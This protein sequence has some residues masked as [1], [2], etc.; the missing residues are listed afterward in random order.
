MSAKVYFFPH[1]FTDERR[2]ASIESGVTLASIV[3]T[4]RSDIPRGL[5]VRTF[6]NGMLISADKRQNTVLNDGDEII[7]RI[8]PA[9]PN[10]S[11]R[12][13]A[14]ES[15][16]IGGIAAMVLGV[17]LLVIGGILTGGA[18]WVAVGAAALVTSGVGLMI[19]GGLTASGVIG[20]PYA[21]EMGTKNH[22]SIR[23]ASNQSDPNG[24]VPLVLGRSLI[25]PGYLCP[26]Y[27]VISGVD[28]KDQY[29]YMSFIL[30]YAPLSVSNIKFGDFLVASNSANTTEGAIAVDGVLPGCE[31]ELRQ[32]GSVISFFEK[33]VI[34]QNFQ[35]LL[36]RYHVLSGLSL[37]VD[38]S[39][40]T[41][42]RS[43][44]DWTDSDNDVQVG[45]YVDFYGFSNYGNNKQFLV[46]GISSTVI[47][48]NQ[49]STLV[50]ETKSDV[51]VIVVP[52]TIQT[53]A[54]NTTQIAVTITFPKLVK[55]HTDDKLYTTV[56]VKPYY[57]LKAATGSPPNPWTL[58]G[59]FDAGSNSITRNKAETLRFTATSGTLTAGQYEV[60]VMRETEDSDD[61]KIVD[62]VYWTS[63]RS[64]T[65]IDAMPQ[66][67]REKV[68][69]LG[70]K[71]KASEAV[72][73]CITKLNCIVSA[74]YSY[75]ATEDTSHDWASII[76]SNPRNA[77]LAFVHAIMGPGNPRPR[78]TSQMDWAS[79]YAFAQWCD[80]AK[81][82]GDNAYKVEINGLITSSMKLSELIVKILSQARASLTMSE[83]K[84]GVV[85][86]AAQSTPKQHIGP[87]NSWGF[88]GK[89]V[90]GEEI[91]GYRVKFINADEEYTTDERIVLDDGYKYDTEADGI[92]RDCWGVD[93]TADA[94]Y[95]EAT[96]FETIEAGLNTNPAQVFG[97]CRYLLA[98]RKLRPELFTVNMDAENLA[99]KRGELVKVTHPAPRWGLA[100]G[101]LTGVTVDGGGNITAVETNN[102]LTME[103]G[104]DYAIRIR[105]ATGT[106]VY[107]TVV[108]DVGD[109]NELTLTTPISAGA[110]M[111]AE[112]DWFAFGIDELETVDCIVAGVD[113]NDDLSA[114]LTLFEAAPAVHTADTGAIPDFVS[115]V[116]FGPVPSAPSTKS[117]VFPP[118]PDVIPYPSE[119]ALSTLSDTVD[120]DGQYGIYNGQR[121]FGTT[122]STW[123]LDDAGQTA[124]DVAALIPIY[125]PAYLGAHLDGAPATA[126]NG[127]SY[128]RYSVTSG[129]EN[130]GV[131]TYDGTTW[132]RTTD[133]I[134]VYKALVDIVFICQL[135]DPDGA[136]LYGTEADYGVTSTIETAHIMAAIIDRLRVGDL[137]IFGTLKSLLMDTINSQA[138]ETINAP[139]P[140]YWPGSALVDHCA[141]LADGWHAVDNASTFGGKNITHVVKGP[142]NDHS[143]EYQ[144][145]ATEEVVAPGST[146]TEYKSLT[147]VVDGKA[148]I[149]LDVKSAGWFKN[150]Y[151]QITK[152]GSVLYSGR[153][154]GVGVWDDTYFND[155]TLAVGDVV[156]LLAYST[157]G[158]GAVA[159]FDIIPAADTI[160]IWNNTD[161]TAKVVESSVYYSLAGNIDVTGLSDFATA[162]YDD[163][164][165]GSEFIS[166]FSGKIT[167]FRTL[168]LGG[169]TFNS[170]TCETI[171]KN[172]TATITLGFTDATTL[173]INSASYYTYAGSV[174]L[175]TVEG[176]ILFGD[177]DSEGQYELWSHNIPGTTNNIITWRNIKTG[178]IFSILEV[179]APDVSSG[180]S[181]STLFLHA[182]VGD[183]D[184]VNDKSM[185]NYSGTMKVVD[186]FSNFGASGA[187][188]A[189]EWWRKKYSESSAVKVASIDANNGNLEIIGEVKGAT[190]AITG[191]ASVGGNLSVTGGVSGSGGTLASTQLNSYKI[192]DDSSPI[193]T[194][195]SG[196]VNAGQRS[197]LFSVYKPITV[198][199]SSGSTSSFYLQVYRDGSYYNVLTNANDAVSLNPGRYAFYNSSGSDSISVGI[200]CVGAYGTADGSSIWS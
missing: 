171:Y 176:K 24:K 175:P 130:R 106:S 16:T 179:R 128:L 67:Y 105:T 108:L 78:P 36:S 91:H 23:G 139:T 17:G 10:D 76:A 182:V 98:V 68:A 181:E 44:G 12:Q 140:T 54:Q 27:T 148:R 165:L 65:G 198:A 183:G 56:V 157:S 172:G 59:T 186:V 162:D 28:G 118:A 2:E 86:D 125:E 50:N 64:H 155:I 9:D 170:K 122:P 46:T 178:K 101:R 48:C 174:I 47:Y 161:N 61:T 100:D 188:G 90:F 185:H 189:W 40:R 29:L 102:M 97:W 110:D 96:K 6:V 137:E 164:W 135:K 81:G 115:K 107:R 119:K 194:R 26:P 15:K 83:G 41:I 39:A 53:T 43:S 199:F 158:N 154:N 151:W 169:G 72:Q 66:A 4:A 147:S 187:L 32:S 144:S 159:N 120:F 197:S 71:V 156:K 149:V 62:Q 191:N 152:N 77:A 19:G 143:I 184:F 35:T 57:R 70:V 134:Y 177:P 173:L 114:K 113:L 95:I 109:T 1:P 60:F 51:G 74:D 92:L 69:T 85:Y 103:A 153:S 112:G 150:T 25:T 136:T 55:Y 93:K 195:S 138:G 131:F 123:T 13:Q 117:Q 116:S 121:Y 21:D 141:S 126:K 63:L 111:P 52:A 166:L 127:D 5:M 200:A 133:P 168:D 14:A 3:K 34:E 88:Q 37:T 192:D 124:A 38:A 180:D 73:N 75:I 145:D 89:K 190:A 42:T 11:D 79:I 31:V 193:A 18:L 132:T 196:L 20:G 30:G 160:G 8:V 104:K 94:G 33:E 82:T 142:G 146:Y 129:N 58:L 22:P 7:V 84:Y 45:D 49:A 87:H 80:T 167:N 99:V 163:Y